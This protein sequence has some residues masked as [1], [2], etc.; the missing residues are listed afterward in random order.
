MQEEET[1]QYLWSMLKIHHF[2]SKW[3]YIQTSL[4]Q[5][6]VGNSLQARDRATIGL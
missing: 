3:A 6:S 2:S 5:I 4:S 1:T